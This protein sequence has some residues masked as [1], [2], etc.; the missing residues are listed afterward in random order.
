MVTHIQVSFFLLLCNKSPGKLTLAC[1]LKLLFCFCK[2]GTQVQ[3]LCFRVSPKPQSSCHRLRSQ[4]E[5]LSGEGSPSK[6]IYMPVV[7]IQL[8]G[9]WAGG[10]SSSL[11]AGCRLPS[12][13]SHMAFLSLVVVV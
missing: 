5:G 9:R 6:L 12:A 2:S 10:L 4:S 13:T 7:R 1:C 8:K 11:A 3:V